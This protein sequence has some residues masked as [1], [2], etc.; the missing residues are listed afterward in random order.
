MKVAPSVNAPAA[1]IL[2][3]DDNR[4][5]LIARK[6][7]LEDLGYRVTTATEGQ[8]AFDRFG[9][10]KFD[11][12]ITDY[13]MPKMDGLQLI[14][15]IRQIAVDL[16]II[17]ISGYAEALGMTEA[18]TGAD[19]VIAKSASEV[20]QLIRSVNRLLRR[21]AVKKPVGSQRGAARLRQRGAC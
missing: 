15:R 17:L 1:R 19:I 10:D 16:P 20:P 7:V 4:L 6:S 12:I 3:V 9:R 2:L 8:E 14:E 18:S 21:P 5:G 11:L 13:K